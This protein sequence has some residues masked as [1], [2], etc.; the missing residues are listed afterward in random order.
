MYPL[1]IIEKYSNK[2]GLNMSQALFLKHFVYNNLGYLN[3][4]YIFVPLWNVLHVLR[5]LCIYNLTRIM[6]MEKDMYKLKK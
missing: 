6:M 1:V 2:Y 4:L 3:V 5:C